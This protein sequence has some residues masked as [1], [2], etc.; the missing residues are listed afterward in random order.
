M[1]WDCFRFGIGSRKT[2]KGTRASLDNIVSRL[3]A[4]CAASGT[5]VDII[6][7]VNGWKIQTNILLIN[8]VI[9]RMAAGSI[10]IH[11]K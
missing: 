9:V 1:I 10:L 5:S 2:G 8:A 11:T 7:R 4:E 6:T 3:G